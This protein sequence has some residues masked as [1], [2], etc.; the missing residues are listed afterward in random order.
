MET[1]KKIKANKKWIIFFA[2]LAIIIVA[3]LFYFKAR[4][5]KDFNPLIKDKLQELVSNGSDGLYQLTY[6]S[7]KSDVYG[8]TVILKNVH[9]F[10]DSSRL[11]HLDSLHMKPEDIFDFSLTTL[12]IDGLDIS[13]FLSNK[14]ID[15]KIIYLNNPT[16]DIYH[17]KND[18][19]KTKKDTASV[20]TVYQR[21]ST[22]LNRF[23]VQK[24]A[25]KN[26]EVIHHNYISD[27]KESTT[28]FDKVNMQFEDLLIDSL[29]QYDSTRFM[30]AKNAAITL[31]KFKLPTPDSLYVISM[32]SIYINAANKTVDIDTL[33]FTPRDG[34]DAF[35]SKMPY[36]K[37][38]YTASFEHISLHDIDWWAFVSNEG[39]SAKNMILQNGKL[40]IYADRNL[41]PFPKSKVGNYPHQML[42]KI[43]LPVSLDSII[44]SNLDMS[45]E[46][47]NPDSKLP[48]KIFFNNINGYIS[49]IN[50]NPT[51]AASPIMKIKASSDLMDAGKINAEFLFDMNKTNSG[52][53]SVSGE[54]GAMDAKKL[55]PVT[56]PLG[57]FK[58]D[59]GKVKSLSFD[60]N[61]NDKSCSGQFKFLYDDLHIQIL[62]KGND[63]GVQEKKGLLSFIANT[64]VIKKSNPGNDGDVRTVMAS[65]VRDIH[66]SF[67]NLIWKTLLDGFK[68][69]VK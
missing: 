53:F 36:L 69:T 31:G 29:T 60:F 25:I 6:D 39:F 10:P 49:N 8:G 62:K 45:Y 15:L 43:S 67:F 65:S 52:A 11:L 32:D 44:I 51:T 4:N 20:Q 40:G 17:E 19:L 16:L 42:M 56:E 46:E 57:L 55:D 34:K 47:N 23:S 59:D 3:G 37:E 9:V 18:S 50:T 68:Q 27:D 66:K 30:Y 48:G 26:M 33:A 5:L 24:L 41:P 35:V 63:N 21:I 14:K 7:L 2:G 22:L 61:G 13:D 54:L 28:R 1:S 64:F 38:R 58:I 12:A